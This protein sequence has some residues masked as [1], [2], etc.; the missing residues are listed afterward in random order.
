MIA[1]R[2]G[3]ALHVFGSITLLVGFVGGLCVWA[4][5]AIGWVNWASFEW[6]PWVLASMMVGYAAQGVGRSFTG[7]DS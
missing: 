1:G 5:N 3:R 7:R 2:I 4:A 6:M